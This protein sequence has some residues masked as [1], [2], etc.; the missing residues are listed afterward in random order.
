VPTRR[1][2]RL[3]QSLWVRGRPRVA[4]GGSVLSDARQTVTL[5]ARPGR[6]ATEGQYASGAET[7]LVRAQLRFAGTGRPISFTFCPA[8]GGT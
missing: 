7:H 4:A 1:G 5:S 2:D 6:R 8:P 3:E